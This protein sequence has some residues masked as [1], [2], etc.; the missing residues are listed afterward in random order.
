[1]R[2]LSICCVALSGSVKPD[3][4]TNTSRNSPLAARPETLMLLLNSGPAVKPNGCDN[5]PTLLVKSPLSKPV[6]LKL[7]L[8]PDPGRAPGAPPFSTT[9][10]EITALQSAKEPSWPLKRQSRGVACALERLL[11]AGLIPKAIEVKNST[12][13]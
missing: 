13:V 5:P 3:A 1:M 7:L 10:M 6:T 8:T 12:P 9:Q 4:V 2:P 11:F